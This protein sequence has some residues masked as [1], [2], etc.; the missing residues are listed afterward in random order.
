MNIGFRDLKRLK[1]YINQLQ[2]VDYV[3]TN[4]A[5]CKKR[6]LRIFEH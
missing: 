3:D 4:S 5:N 2:C 1:K 6:Q